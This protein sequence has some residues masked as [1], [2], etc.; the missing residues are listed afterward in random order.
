MKSIERCGKEMK[1]L[2]DLIIGS[3][4]VL[5]FLLSSCSSSSYTKK[6]ANI[7]PPGILTKTDNFIIQK[8]GKD[9]FEKYITTDFEK[10]KYVAPY[11]NMV[12]RLVIPDKSY[13]NELITFSVDTIGNIVRDINITGIPNCV[14]EDCNFNITED[15]AVKIAKD[16]GLP[17]GIKDW[18]TEFTWNSNLNQYVW[19]IISTDQASESTQGFRGSGKEIIIDANTGLVI[20]MHDWNIK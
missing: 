7:V 18:K 8:T 15:Q 19:Q 16:S 5:G 13:V 10:T 3:V 6:D 2:S 20:A 9:F 11:Y 17:I 12:Y 14:E 1:F 4:I